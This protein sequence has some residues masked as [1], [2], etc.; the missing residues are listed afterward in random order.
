MAQVMPEIA[1][2]PVCASRLFSS[3]RFFASCARCGFRCKPKDFPRISAAME[4]AIA[5]A[6]YF[7]LGTEAGRKRLQEAGQRALE[8]FK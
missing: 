8:V 5:T 1:N 6:A 3:N 7:T 4:L 2:C